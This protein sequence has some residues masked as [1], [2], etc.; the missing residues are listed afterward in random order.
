MKK[1]I[2]LIILGCMV[3]TLSSCSSDKVSSDD[4]RLT[5]IRRDDGEEGEVYYDPIR[6]HCKNVVHNDDFSTI[7]I[8]P[9]IKIGSEYDDEIGLRIWH[10][11]SENKFL[12]YSD[13]DRVVGILSDDGTFDELF[14]WDKDSYIFFSVLSSILFLFSTGAQ[15]KKHQLQH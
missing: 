8:S 9:E 1:I 2:S 6:L 3:P 12:A 14:A 5:H 15:L 11:F 10:V 4:E 13:A 7:E